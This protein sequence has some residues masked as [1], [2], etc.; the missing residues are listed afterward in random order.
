MFEPLASGWTADN[1]AVGGM[2]VECRG[3]GFHGTSEQ[4]LEQLLAFAASTWTPWSELCPEYS[5]VC[6]IQTHIKEAQGNSDDESVINA[7]MMCCEL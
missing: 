4:A 2:M 3:P 1:T 6:G 5:A 7:K